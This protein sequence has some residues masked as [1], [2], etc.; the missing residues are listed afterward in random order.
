MRVTSR[1]ERDYRNTGE[2]VNGEVSHGLA[3]DLHS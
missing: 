2:Q 1:V 3:H